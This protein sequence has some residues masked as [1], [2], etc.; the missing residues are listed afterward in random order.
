MIKIG[1]A[2]IDEISLNHIKAIQS[3]VGFQISG[4]YDSLTENTR[5]LCEKKG[6]NYFED[7]GELLQNSDVVDIASP[8]RKSVV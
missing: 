4:I 7:F 1:V 5:E 2:G 8:D 3:L 6:L